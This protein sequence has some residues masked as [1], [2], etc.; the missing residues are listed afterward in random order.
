MKSFLQQ[1]AILTSPSLPPRTTSFLGCLKK[2]KKKRLLTGT[3][4]YF[5]IVTV[6][7]LH[8]KTAEAVAENLTGRPSSKIS[9]RLESR[10]N[11]PPTP[12]WVCLRRCQLM[13]SVATYA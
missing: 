10:T 2:K 5:F 8:M 9:F 7:L 1:T 11:S 13:L 3:A 6:L 4:V 12:P